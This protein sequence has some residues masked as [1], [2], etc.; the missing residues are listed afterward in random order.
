MSDRPV[1]ADDSADWKP[2]QKRTKGTHLI[3]HDGLVR[4]PSTPLYSQLVHATK[5]PFTAAGKQ[6]I[7]AD[8]ARA[9]VDSGPKAA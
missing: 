1:F 3:I 9:Q 4:Q 8:K 7:S 2:L 6:P 5:F